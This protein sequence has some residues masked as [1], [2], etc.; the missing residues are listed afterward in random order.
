MAE[1]VEI[2]GQNAA[3]LE[4]NA[5]SRV[6]LK[7]EPAGGNVY[8]A[9]KGELNRSGGIADEYRSL[10]D[11]VTA[12]PKD[13]VTQSESIQ[14]KPSNGSEPLRVMEKAGPAETTPA[15]GG[16]AKTAGRL[17]RRRHRGA[18]HGRTAPDRAV[19]GR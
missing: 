1:L 2:R 15:T 7:L 16:T 14:V 5:R 8:L 4:G 18:H 6:M 11:E 3:A 12:G 10:G 13:P 9:K 17:L 19:G